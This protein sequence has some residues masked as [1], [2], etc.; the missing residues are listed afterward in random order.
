MSPR[1][2]YDSESIENLENLETIYERISASTENHF[3]SHDMI[4]TFYGSTVEPL[5]ESQPV[6]NDK[7]SSSTIDQ[8]TKP[9]TMS[10]DEISINNICDSWPENATGN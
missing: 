3:A 2:D 5:I 4:G 7:S 6:I 10:N 9:T 8:T 1:L